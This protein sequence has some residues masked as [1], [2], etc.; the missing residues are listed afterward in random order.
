VLRFANNP[1]ESKDR[2]DRCN[3]NI[4]P[5][6]TSVRTRKPKCFTAGSTSSSVAR[7]IHAK[8]LAHAHCTRLS[9]MTSSLESFLG[10]ARARFP[11]GIQKP[12]SRLPTACRLGVC[13]VGRK[14]YP[15]AEDGVRLH[16]DNMRL[17]HSLE[18]L[19]TC[20]RTPIGSIYLR[21]EKFRGFEFERVE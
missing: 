20:V 2:S 17:R 12:I 15:V 6:N 14:M 16:S 18:I 5:C 7:T 1:I 8:T 10:C 13:Q 11:R 3:P 9:Y 21:I 19:S 4:R